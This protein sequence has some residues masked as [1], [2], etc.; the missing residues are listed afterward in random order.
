MTNITDVISSM[1]DEQIT[2][3]MARLE[4]G[5]PMWLRLHS[6]QTERMAI[7]HEKEIGLDSS[8]RLQ[9]YHRYKRNVTRQLDAKTLYDVNIEGF[10]SLIE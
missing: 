8:R 10:K 4:N 3:M 9:A 2:K 6:E 1:S 5:S 7:A